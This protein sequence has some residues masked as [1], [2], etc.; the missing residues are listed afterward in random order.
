MRSGTVSLR[1]PLVRRTSGTG[2]SFSRGGALW[3]TPLTGP[4]RASRKSLT[5]EHFSNVGLE[6]AMELAM[7]LI[8][9]EFESL[10]EVERNG[11][12]A[13]FWPEDST[14]SSLLLPAAPSGPASSTVI[15]KLSQVFVEMLMGFPVG[16]TRTDE[17]D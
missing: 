3:P 7:G 5:A 17:S 10:E 12:A 15:P 4:M 14:T 6:Q 1:P 8:P 9:R 2:S 13:R 16:W 11:S